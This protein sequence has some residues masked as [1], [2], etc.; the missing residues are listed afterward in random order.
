MMNYSKGQPLG[1]NNVPQF[2]S[3]A[4]IKALEQY[5]LENGTA[6]SVIT[7]TQNTTAVEI[8]TG[9]TAAVMAWIATTDTTASVIAIAGTTANY[10]H[11]IPANTVR[12]FVVP[13][14]A[15]SNSQGYSSMVGDNRAYGLYQRVAIKSQGI[16]SV[17]TSEYGKSNSY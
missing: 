9:G 3:P 8:A 17:L 1:D 15:Q 6:S 5:V 2:L 10:D 14:E 11:V 13:I 16:G 4:P 12:R 7:L